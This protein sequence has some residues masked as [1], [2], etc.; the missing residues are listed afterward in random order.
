M[1]RATKRTEPIRRIVRASE[2]NRHE[3]QLMGNAYEHA[4]PIYPCRQPDRKD[5]EVKSRT[6]D[7][8]R[9]QASAG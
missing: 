7:P 5:A 6:F 2:P 3:R 9:S 4:V 1:E 8:Q